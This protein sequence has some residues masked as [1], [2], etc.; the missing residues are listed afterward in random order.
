MDIEFRT[1]E[2][3]KAYQE[4]LLHKAL[5][6]LKENSR[7]YQ[8]VFSENG[9]DI[10]EIRHL[11]DLERIPFTEKKDLQLYNDDFCCVPRSKIIDY[12]TTSG[13]LGEPV[14][15]GCT[16]ADLDRL[17]YNEEKSFRCA[18]LDENSVLQL[19]T[20]ID[21]RF[22][23]GLAYFLGLR[24][25]GAGVI[26]VGNGIPEL[27]W[28][29]IRRFRPDSIMCVPSFILK[30]IEY[31]EAHGID[32][33]HSSIRKII[34]IGE[35]LR[36]Q[37]FSL[38][39]LGR[40]IHEK[41]PEVKLYA[42]YSSTEMGATFSECDCGQGGHVH[43]EL[44]IVEIIGEDGKPVPDGQPGEVVVTTLG[45]EAMPLLRFRTGDVSVKHTGQCGCGRWSYRLSPLLGRKNNMIKL[46]GT[47]LYPPAV[48]DVLDNTEYVDNYVVI[49]RNSDAGTD[50]VLVKV[51]LKYTPDFDVVKELKDRF[52]SRIR[53]APAIEI[54]PA[55]EIAAINFPAKS[56]KPVKFIDERKK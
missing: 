31:A 50:D 13:T 54:C 4:E 40:R 37:D 20:T 18:G 44:I 11:E 43:P 26:R 7:Y 19:M 36:E 47:T 52:R 10:D 6:Y 12:I 21:K 30:L 45:V 23:A 24:K 2:E 39:L 25:M 27:Q 34:G 41:W 3:I 17:A 46:K 42:T 28:D 14:L 56:R 55:A 32:Y 5:V 16:D 48:N 29:T 1:P 35:G 22:M 53:V 49:V 51:G 8:R 15:F 33:R 38:N 9:I